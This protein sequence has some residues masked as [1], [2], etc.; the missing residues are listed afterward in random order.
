[1]DGFLAELKRMNPR[2]NESRSSLRGLLTHLQN[3]KFNPTPLMTVPQACQ[4]CTNPRDSRL[5]KYQDAIA[6][7]VGVW[8]SIKPYPG[9]EVSIGRVMFRG[10][11][12]TPTDIFMHGFSAKRQ[13]QIQYRDVEQD[14]DPKTAVAM[15]PSAY[16]AANFPLPSTA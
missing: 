15:S 11:S 6:H 7:L 2:F 4:R 12:R 9:H 10:D 1:M 14:I 8:A 3:T 13:G 16:V 5:T